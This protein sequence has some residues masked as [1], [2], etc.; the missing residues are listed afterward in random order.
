MVYLQEVS[1]EVVNSDPAVQPFLLATDD[2]GFLEVKGQRTQV[3]SQT[4]HDSLGLLHILQ[5]NLKQKK[6][7]RKINNI[8]VALL[9]HAQSCESGGQR[10]I[11]A[12]KIKSRI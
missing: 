4:C 7:G 11:F 9:E 3:L 10:F 6:N 2:G 1:H 5:S 12:T 8:S